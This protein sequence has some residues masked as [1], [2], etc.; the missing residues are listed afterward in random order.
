MFKAQQAQKNLFN[1]LKIINLKNVY[2]N[3]ILES[4]FF[5]VNCYVQWNT[6]NTMNFW[7]LFISED[8]MT[9]LESIR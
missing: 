8:S 6:Y 2:D 5:Y 3:E 4:I 1:T 7:K 9:S